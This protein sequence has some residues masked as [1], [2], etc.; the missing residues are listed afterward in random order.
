MPFESRCFNIT[1]LRWVIS[2]TAP[3]EIADYQVAHGD[4]RD[5]GVT[6]IQQADQYSVQV[7]QSVVAVSLYLSDPLTPG[8]VMT[9]YTAGPAVNN[10]YPF[11][12]PIT[13]AAI[14]TFMS[15]VTEPKAAAAQFRITTAS[16]EN[17]YN[18]TIYI[19]PKQGTSTTADP[20]A[21][22]PAISKSEALGLFPT[23]ERAPGSFDIWP[24][25]TGR[26]FKVYWHDDGT[27]HGDEL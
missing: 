8:T 7:L 12:L 2:P 23:K 4:A 15:G 19:A 10:E 22:D 26:R 24:T 16:G 17:R 11:I 6:F 21:P 5:F 13:G 20:A 14:D 1:T 9:S 27:F 18:G 25:T 3:R